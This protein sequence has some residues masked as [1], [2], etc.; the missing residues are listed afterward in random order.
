MEAQ[1][2]GSSTPSYNKVVSSRGRVGNKSKPPHSLEDK[3]KIRETQ[4]EEGY[5]IHVDDGTHEED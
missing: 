2:G 5:K 3:T 1:G 4:K